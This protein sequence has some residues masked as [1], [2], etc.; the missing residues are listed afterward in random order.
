MPPELKALL[1]AGAPGPH[2]F[3]I[4][5]NRILPQG[6]SYVAHKAASVDRAINLPSKAYLARGWRT[7]Y[8]TKLA[9]PDYSRTGAGL[10]GWRS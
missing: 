3:P 10:R 4:D 9:N 6:R 7:G 2:N 1:R 5:D 8:H